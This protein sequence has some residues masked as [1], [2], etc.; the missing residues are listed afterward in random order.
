[1]SGSAPPRAAIM[2]SLASLVKMRPFASAAASR[3][4]CF[5]C[6]PMRL[7]VAQN[8]EAGK[9]SRHRSAG[10]SILGLMFAVERLRLRQPTTDKPVVELVVS[11][12]FGR[13][14]RSEGWAGFTLPLPL[15]TV[16]F[17]W[18]AKRAQPISPLVR[19]H[20]FVHVQQLGGFFLSGWLRYG[21]A[22]I[23]AG[24]RYRE[25]ALEIEAYAVERDAAK[26]GLPP[27][28]REPE[29]E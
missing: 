26:N 25:N 9:R 15:V 20:E 1:M 27:W 12:F 17:Y 23:R 4:F 3:P 8:G 16:I 2:I 28:A 18:V 13:W 6:A 14:M 21:A 19:V 29:P 22:M 24:G 7:V 5:H 10:A 11:N